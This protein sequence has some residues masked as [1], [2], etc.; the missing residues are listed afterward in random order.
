MQAWKT[1]NVYWRIPVA[2]QPNLSGCRFIATRRNSTPCLNSIRPRVALLCA[3][4]GENPHCEHDEYSSHHD[5]R[6]E[7]RSNWRPTPIS[8]NRGDNQRKRGD[9]GF[10]IIWHSCLSRV[11]QTE[12][13]GATAASSGR[14]GW[15]RKFVFR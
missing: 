7:F 2:N 8:Q 10:D 4:L 11:D 9:H 13:T 12:P 1:A 15:L 6:G 14:R 5:V 3:S